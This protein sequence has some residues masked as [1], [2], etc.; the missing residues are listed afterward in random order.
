MIAV[1]TDKSSLDELAYPPWRLSGSSI[2]PELHGRHL[3][4]NVPLL[5]RSIPFIQMDASSV[6]PKSSTRYETSIW[7]QIE[8]ATS[9][10]GISESDIL[11]CIVDNDTDVKMSPEKEFR[12]SLKFRVEKNNGPHYVE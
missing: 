6:M 4:Q 8:I 2:P 10:E 3:H 1:L 11:A 12:I 9:I 5:I 7:D